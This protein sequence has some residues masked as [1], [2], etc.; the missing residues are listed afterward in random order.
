MKKSNNLIFLILFA[1]S[2]S[3]Q[4]DLRLVGNGGGTYIGE[5]YQ[6]TYSVG[7]TV[8]GL[9]TAGGV[10]ALQGF[11]QPNLTQGVLPVTWLSFTAEASGKVNLLGW[12]VVM[13]GRE[14]SFVVERSSDG[15]SF[16]AVHELE[17]PLYVGDRAFAFV[18]VDYPAALLFYRVRQTDQDGRV[19][20]SPVRTLDRRTEATSSFNLYPN[21][22]SDEVTWSNAPP[23]ASL[24]LHDAVGRLVLQRSLATGPPKMHVSHLAAGAYFYTVHFAGGTR[25]GKLI[26]QRR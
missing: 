11:Q 17:A 20:T 4:T 25:W 2:L 16:S 22:A 10:S 26:I 15:R 19:T 5:R 13:T 6:V 14:E 3:A 7:E 9:R 21:P 8:V 18:D 24:Q 1:A 12:S 23:K